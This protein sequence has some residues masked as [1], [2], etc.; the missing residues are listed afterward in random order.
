MTKHLS[1]IHP[2]INSNHE[3]IPSLNY[4]VDYKYELF[5]ADIGSRLKIKNH[6]FWVYYTYSKYRQFNYPTLIQT[7]FFNEE[8]IEE[9]SY[10]YAHDFP[11]HFVDQDYLGDD[12]RFYN[13]TEQ[14]VEKKIKARVDYWRNRLSKIKSS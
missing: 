8:T 1:R 14:G 10:K 12:K 2:Y 6:K 3:V 9:L 5:S 11:G 13:P 7:Y 4:H